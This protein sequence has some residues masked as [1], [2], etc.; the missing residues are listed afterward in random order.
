L[1]DNISSEIAMNSSNSIGGSKP[2]G[3]SMT[4]HIIVVALVATGAITVYCN[5]GKTREYQMAAIAQ[6]VSGGSVTLV[7]DATG[8]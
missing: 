8:L 3:Q 6:G 2:L 1:D 7:I 4:Q 5:F